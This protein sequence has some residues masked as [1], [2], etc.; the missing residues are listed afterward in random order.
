VHSAF[1][2]E[3]GFL[4]GDF[5]DRIARLAL[6]WGAQQRDA[7]R[8]VCCGVLQ[9]VAV[10]CSVLQCVAVGCS[11]LQCVAVCSSGMLSGLCLSSPSCIT[12]SCKFRD[13]LRDSA[14]KSVSTTLP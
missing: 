13:L 5:L 7:F 4:T 8:A 10:Y 11:V 12:D 2:S 3:R 9:C 6:Q 1:P 14:F